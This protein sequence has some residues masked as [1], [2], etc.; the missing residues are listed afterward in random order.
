MK[1]LFQLFIILLLLS[2]KPSQVNKSNPINQKSLNAFNV[3][4]WRSRDTATT[5]TVNFKLAE[6]PAAA[7]I[8]YDTE[9]RNGNRESYKHKKDAT[10]F[11]VKKLANFHYFQVELKDLE[12]ATTYYYMTADEAGNFSAE[13]KFK[14]LPNDHRD[15]TFVTGGDMGTD[16]AFIPL[17]KLAAAKSPDFALIGGDIAYSDGRI[18]NWP[19]W[20]K[21]LQGWDRNM[22]TPEGYDIPFAAAVG[23]H[24]VKNVLIG[25]RSPLYS[26]IL[27]Q[28]SK[29]Y[30]TRDFG[31]NLRVF[32]LDTGH[33]ATYFG[34]QLGWM[35]DE[36]KK[37]QD[38]RIPFRFG[39]YHIPLYPSHR[40]YLLLSAQIG[41][42]FWAPLFDKYGLHT[43]FEN[44]DH[45]VKRSHILKDGK[46]SETGR[47][48]LYLGDGCW[49]KGRR[50]ADP[51][52]WY[53]ANAEGIEHFWHVKVDPDKAYYQAVDLNGKIVDKYSRTRQV[54][55]ENL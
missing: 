33:L 4:T 17:L 20:I 52:R 37:A 2:F 32:I 22:V 3:L 14:T 29:S 12:P 35:E 16:G 11:G 36:L 9:S 5:I 19:L 7:K 53:L 6:S 45:T 39:L 43:A 38:K 26:E 15:I 49:G 27:R 55:N 13:R 10:Q 1:K 24:E 25:K 21:W 31:K 47:G 54:R 42:F 28:D 46:V 44:H 48:V 51:S 23:N 18:E 8:Y 50:D 41:R 30:F 34:H 40:P